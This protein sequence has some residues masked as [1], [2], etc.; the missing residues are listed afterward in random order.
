[1]REL[2]RRAD[3]EARERVARVEHGAQRERAA[4]DATWERFG[5]QLALLADGDV[6][7][8][9][10]RADHVGDRLAQRGEQVVVHAQHHE[11]RSA[12]EPELGRR[13]RD[14]LE[15]PDELVEVA[16][17]DAIAEAIE[18]GTPDP[19]E[20]GSRRVANSFFHC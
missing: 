7:M 17:A 12:P 19:L 13:E 16:L 11:P 5:E 3:H 2:V 9:L 4:V 6:E 18:N 15:R 14:R 8:H 20:R 10:S 1:M